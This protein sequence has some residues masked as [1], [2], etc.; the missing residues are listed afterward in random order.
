MLDLIPEY[1]DSRKAARA[2]KQRLEADDERGRT[3]VNGM[4][5]D[6][7][8]A[9]EWLET[10]RQP[11]YY[12]PDETKQKGRSQYA[13][14]ALLDMDLF[15]CIDLDTE[16]P[17][18]MDDERKRLITEVLKSL[19]EREMTMFVIHTAHMRSIAEVA[20]ELGVAKSTAQVTIERAKRKI[21]KL[22]REKNIEL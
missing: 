11:Q 21:R 2:L 8:Y 1:R 20:K 9:I 4:I 18:P 3:A 5:S 22:V 14:R 17:E 6:L 15:P 7:N 19:T 12:G 16:E 10:G 13:R